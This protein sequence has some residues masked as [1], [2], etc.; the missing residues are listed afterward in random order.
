MAAKGT[1]N[2]PR[3]IGTVDEIRVTNFKINLNSEGE[4][5][6]SAI[7]HEG[8]DVGGVFEVGAVGEINILESGLNAANKTRLNNI[9]KTL[10]QLYVNEKGYSASVS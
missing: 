3:S 1:F 8:T 9:F 2:T 6:L 7:L 10:L 4:Y 5:E